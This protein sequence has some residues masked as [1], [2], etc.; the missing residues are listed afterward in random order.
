MLRDPPMVMWRRYARVHGAT[1]RGYDVRPADD[2]NML[3]VALET[4][5]VKFLIHHFLSLSLCSFSSG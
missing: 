3:S 5:Q 1:L 4:F 2:S